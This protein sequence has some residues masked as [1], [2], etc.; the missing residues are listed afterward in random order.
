MTILTENQSSIDLKQLLILLN[1]DLQLRADL[2]LDLDCRIVTDDPRTL[3][4]LFRNVIVSIRD[5]STGWLSIGLSALR[6]SFDVAIVGRCGNNITH[7]EPIAADTFSNFG[8]VAFFEFVPQSY[9]KVVIRFER[10]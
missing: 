9:V 7:A 3:T 10:H 1:D 5:H 8:G 4:S 6:D 2:C